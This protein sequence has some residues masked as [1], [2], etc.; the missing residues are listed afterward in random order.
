[1]SPGKQTLLTETDAGTYLG[2]SRSFLAKSRCNGTLPNHT[3]GPP[4]I[5]L[6]H[7][8]RYDVRDLDAWIAANRKE[9]KQYA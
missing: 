7:A 3:P 6:G 5:K 9:V 2:V 1:M 8:I 4:Y